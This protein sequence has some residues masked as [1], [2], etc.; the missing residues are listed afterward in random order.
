MPTIFHKDL[1]G[2]QTS[3]QSLDQ[4]SDT[5]SENNLRARQVIHGS[6][7]CPAAGC[8]GMEVGYRYQARV[9]GSSLEHFFKVRAEIRNSIIKYL[10]RT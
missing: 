1:D 6:A 5:R 4:N 3:L 8:G 10:K 9:E 2:L 7:R